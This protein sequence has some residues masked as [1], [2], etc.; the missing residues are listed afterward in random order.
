MIRLATT[1]DFDDILKLS[2]EFWLHTQFTEPF[3]PEH[4]LKMVE[5]SHDQG[6]LSVAESKGKIIGFA[7]GIYSALLGNSTVLAGTELAWWIDKEHRGGQHGIMLL[8]FMESRAKD[9][10][11]RYWNMVAMESSMPE[12]VKSMYEKMGYTHQESTFTKVI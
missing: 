5:F 8:K 10:G 4:T 11:I 2:A 6:F 7:A 3:E 1:K 12:Q 9:L